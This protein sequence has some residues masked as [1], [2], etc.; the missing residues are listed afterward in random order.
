MRAA[1][2]LV[3]DARIEPLYGWVDPRI[4]RAGAV[5]PEHVAM[6]LHAAGIPLDVGA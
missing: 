3:P 5:T 1:L 6:V 2:N 4:L